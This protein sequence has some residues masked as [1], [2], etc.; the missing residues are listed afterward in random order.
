MNTK[1]EKDVQAEVPIVINMPKINLISF[2]TCFLFFITFLILNQNNLLPVLQ[3][4]NQTEPT[5]LLPRISKKTLNNQKTVGCLCWILRNFPLDGN[6]FIYFQY[7]G[8]QPLGQLNQHWLAC[9]V[10]ALT[11][12]YLVQTPPICRHL[13]IYVVFQGFV[14]IYIC[15]DGFF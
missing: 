12:S 11:P 2:S 4:L 13:N 1:E 6:I 14:V 3:H 9:R 8:Q 7:F 10:I 5:C 15:F